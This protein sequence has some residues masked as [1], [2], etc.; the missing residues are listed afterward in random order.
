MNRLRTLGAAALCAAALAVT[1]PATAHAGGTKDPQYSHPPATTAP[2]TGCSDRAPFVGDWVGYGAKEI[3]LDN[4]GSGKITFG[5]NT[6]NT[7]TWT[8]T[9]NPQRAEIF[10]KCG[11][12]TTIDRPIS[13]TG[14]GSKGVLAAGKQYQA[15]IGQRGEHNALLLAV[16]P[17][18]DSVVFCRKGEDLSTCG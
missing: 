16:Y 15:I 8:L 11:I 14:A 2:S 9:W 1:L 6:A 10:Q 17:Q 4:N 7:E 5:D 12:L 13:K 18:A 3:V